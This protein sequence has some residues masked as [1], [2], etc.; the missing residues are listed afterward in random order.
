MLKFAL[1]LAIAVFAALAL[2]ACGSSGIKVPKEDPNRRGAELFADRCSGCHTLEAAGT[3]GS[4]GD[5]KTSG[6]DLDKSKET[7]DSV[8]YAIYN[9]GFG[10]KIMPSNIVMGENAD[11]VAEFVA[12]YAGEKI[13][14]SA[15]EKKSPNKA[16][17]Q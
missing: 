17:S 8:L 6:P 10:G 13:K 16:Q 14:P 15:G 2:S 9:G 3:E 11:R 12:K 1:L 5:Y 7:V 4:S